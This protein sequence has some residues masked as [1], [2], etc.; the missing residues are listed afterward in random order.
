MKL[1]WRQLWGLLWAYINKIPID[2]TGKV[3]KLSRPTVYRWYGLFRQQLPDMEEV[4][5]AGVVQMDEAYFGRKKTGQVAIIAAKSISSKQ[6]AAIVI[7]RSAVNRAD[8]VPF[9][10]QHVVPESK[11]WTDGAA[12]YRGIGNH[13]PLEHDYDVH[14]KAEFGKTSQIEGFWGSLRTYIRRMYHHVTIAKLPHL[15]RE[16]QHR[17]MHPEIFNSP[18]SFLHKTLTTVSFA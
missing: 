10:Q 18:A 4:R 12:I 14:R 7:P 3:L 2:Q 8:I 5:L 16:Y 17:L 6:V 9:I 11:L 15:L 13:W 1:S